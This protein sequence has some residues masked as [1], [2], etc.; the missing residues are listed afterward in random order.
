[1]RTEKNDKDTH[2]PGH[3]PSVSWQDLV[4]NQYR[5]GL[6]CIK[7]NNKACLDS[8]VSRQQSL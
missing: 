2:G 7:V 4:D 5:G 1:M 8:L 3:D 6:R